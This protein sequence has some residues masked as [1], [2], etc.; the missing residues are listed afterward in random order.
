MWVAQLIYTN[1]YNLLSYKHLHLHLCKIFYTQNAKLRNIL[2]LNQVSFRWL[3][4]DI[5]FQSNPISICNFNQV[6]FYL[7]LES[8][9]FD[10]QK[11]HTQRQKPTKGR[12]SHN[13][14][15][16]VISYL[17]YKQFLPGQSGQKSRIR[18]MLFCSNSP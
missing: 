14:G 18:C 15:Q 8:R 6:C 11:K 9:N 5:H 12:I 3:L 1:S 17:W 16:T 4:I 10:D 2:Y 13:K 7:G